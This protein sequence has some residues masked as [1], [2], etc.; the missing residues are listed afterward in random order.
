[1]GWMSRVVE[2]KPFHILRFS[3]LV[4][5]F[6]RAVLIA[7]GAALAGICVNLFIHPKP[8]PFIATQPYD[9]Y[10][11][12]PE[13]GELRGI[14]KISAEA[15]SLA[16]LE[17]KILIDS[18]P[19]EEFRKGH[20]PGAISMPHDPLICPLPETVEMLKQKGLIVI[21]YGDGDPNSGVLLVEELQREGLKNV[22]FLEGGFSGWREKGLPV[23]T[24][25]GK[26]GKAETSDRKPATSPKPSVLSPKSGRV[27]SKE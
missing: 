27:E 8:I 18:R 25:A 15:L 19:E 3:E 26:A 7:A 14:E 12:C 2:K 13:G 21:V 5:I 9:V 1:M 23:E 4:P 17:Q 10:V 20:I 6:I 24:E 11:V 16:E 22:M